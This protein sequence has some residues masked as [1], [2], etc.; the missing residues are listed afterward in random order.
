MLVDSHCHLDFPDFGDELEDVIA[1]ARAAGVDWMVTIGTHVSRFERVRALAA[2]HDNVFCTVGNHPH[3]VAAE[4]AATVDALVRLARH[5]KVI[6]FGESGLDYHYE[7]SPRDRQRESFRVHIAAAREAGLP[8]VVHSRGADED[9]IR[10]L[11][12]EHARGPFAGL[13]HCFSTGRALA[14]A[15]VAM[16]FYVSFSG[17]V[18][19]KNA[20]DIRVTARALP[21]ERILVE[22]D[23]P[24]LAPEPRRGR[25]NEPAFVVHTA[26]R[27]ARERGLAPEALAQAT[28]ENFFRLFARARALAGDPR[29]GTS[30]CA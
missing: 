11:E 16:G 25:R 5:P 30:A 20:D 17:I 4:P 26:E 14:E 13:I 18:T 10:I 28:T 6:G 2:A 21:V 12:D 15:A 27:L 1:R 19:F 8:L 29:G 9:T 7:L 24:Y 3:H 23:A 22:T